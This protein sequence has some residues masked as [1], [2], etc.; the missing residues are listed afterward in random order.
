MSFS[1]SVERVGRHSVNFPLCQLMDLKKKKYLQKYFHIK[2]TVPKFTKRPTN[3]FFSKEIQQTHF[4]TNLRVNLRHLVRPQQSVRGT[5]PPSPSRTGSR[6]S[7]TRPP[8]S[9]RR[10][11]GPTRGG[12]RASPCL[13][14][15]PPACTRGRARTSPR[16]RR[17][18]LLFRII[19]GVTS[20]LVPH[21]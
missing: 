10:P 5:S 6:G 16:R 17:R 19:T 20:R 18:R 11:T 7:S 1:R 13:G 21:R 14:P 12:R 9:Y 4:P 15:A 8:R 2:I 3:L